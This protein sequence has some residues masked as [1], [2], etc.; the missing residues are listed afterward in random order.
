MQLNRRHFAPFALCCLLLGSVHAA[1][2][3]PAGNLGAQAETFVKV[4]NP[5]YLKDLRKV[6]ITNFTVDFV[7]EL[8]Y[9]KALSGLGALMGGDSNVTVKLVGADHELYQRL[10]D[11]LYDKAVADLQARGIEVVPAETLEADSDYQE[12]VKHGVTPLP[13]EQDAKSGKGLYF[14]ARKLPMHLLDET[15]FITQIQ[16]FGKKKEDEF[17]TFGSRFSGGFTAGRIQMSEEALAKKLDASLLKVRLT[18]LGGQLTPDTSFW[19]SGKVSTRA[20]VTFVDFVNRYAFIS[21][22]GKRSRISLKEMVATDD[23]GELVNVTSTGT[24]TTDAVQNTAMVAL[25]V[26]GFAAR[27]Q[28]INAPMGG[29]YAASTDFE[30]RVQPENFEKS[31]LTH[32]GAIAGM[33]GEKLKN[34]G[35]P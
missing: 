16:F 3:D 7:S 8:K 17:L 30:C 14:S 28:G 21:P 1:G 2:L 34:P 32:F 27:L 13:S 29:S 6:A 25:N 20:A 12:L 11:Q 9:N 5:E 24:K 4:E 31:V 22:A 15:Q 35:T 18:V 26:I 23:V 19:S 10:T 33:F